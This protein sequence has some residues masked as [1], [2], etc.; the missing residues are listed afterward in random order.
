MTP[1]PPNVVPA[2]TYRSSNPS[3]SA[4]GR[5][6]RHFCSATAAMIRKSSWEAPAAAAST[7]I[8]MV[9]ARSSAGSFFVHSAIAIAQDLEMSL[10]ARAAAISGW[11][12]SSRICRISALASW[13]V[14]SVI[15]ISHAA[16][17]PYPSQ[18]CASA[19]SNRASTSACAAVNF[20]CTAASDRSTDPARGGVQLPGA[21]AVEVVQA[22]VHHPQRIGDAHPGHLLPVLPLVN[23][24]SAP[25]VW[26]AI[27]IAQVF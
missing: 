3:S 14:M 27:K 13:R 19:A 18:S 2:C 15:A 7:R 4:S 9:S 6:E 11:S 24:S 17:L 26:P 21:R 25:F 22:G 10:A 12:R 16:E 20:A 23:P 5:E 1:A 8:L